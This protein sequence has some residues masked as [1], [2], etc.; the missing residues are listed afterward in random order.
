[1]KHDNNKN[2]VKQ[3]NDKNW[4]YI[5]KV[6]HAVYRFKVFVARSWAES[7]VTGIGLFGELSNAINKLLHIFSNT[8]KGL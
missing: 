5:S 1:M 3:V 2:E 8:N 7:R 4:F 6:K